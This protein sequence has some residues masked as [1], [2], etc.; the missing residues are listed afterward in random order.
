MLDE[1]KIQVNHTVRLLCDNKAAISIGKNPVQHDKTKH[2]KIDR[3]FIKEK[4]DHKIISIDHVHHASK[5]HI[6]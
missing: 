1:I 2:V 3:H 6:S 4:I 5:L